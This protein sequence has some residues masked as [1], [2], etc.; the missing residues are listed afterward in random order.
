[1]DFIQKV[2]NPGASQ[3]NNGQSNQLFT[4]QEFKPWDWPYSF[5]SGFYL[6][7][8]NHYVINKNFFFK[9]LIAYLLLTLLFH[10][11]LTTCCWFY[12]RLQNYP[13]MSQTDPGTTGWSR[14]KAMSAHLVLP[15]F[16]LSL[17]LSVVYLQ[18]KPGSESWGVFLVLFLV[19][20]FFGVGMQVGTLV[21]W[22]TS[23]TL[24]ILSFFFL[25]P[26]SY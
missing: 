4:P 13:R 19:M 5:W 9:G 10:A 23:I 22:L 26:Q 15:S 8:R 20:S 14:W 6:W 11:L 21:G 3:S 7:D 1:M 16:M 2:T 18:W 25:M 24:S 12:D 17:F